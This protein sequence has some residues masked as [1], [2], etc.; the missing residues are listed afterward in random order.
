VS[1]SE[2]V[3]TSVGGGACRASC[4]RSIGAG[5]V[6]QQQVSNTLDVQ[7]RVCCVQCV[8]RSMDVQPAV[9]KASTRMSVTLETCVTRSLM[10]MTS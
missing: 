5:A 10:D 1:I 9:A 3:D 4:I 7:E 6:G 8:V 2:A